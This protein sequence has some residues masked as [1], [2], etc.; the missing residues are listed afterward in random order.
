[1]LREI[2]F[3]RTIEYSY[4]SLLENSTTIQTVGPSGFFILSQCI[5]ILI[6]MFIIYGVQ[7]VRQKN[8]LHRASERF[9]RSRP[10]I[11]I[12]GNKTIGCRS[13]V[14]IN[15]STTLQAGLNQIIFNRCLTSITAP[16][17]EQVL[18]ANDLTTT[19]HDR[20]TTRPS[21]NRDLI[22]VKEFTKR[23]SITIENSTDTELHP[24]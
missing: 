9:I 14:A 8:L 11:S 10:Y 12:F 6:M 13:N 21:I 16:I 15:P 17:E 7:T 24:M 4:N 20:R 2:I 3:C 22:D 23:M 5:I 1:M 19:I 18:A